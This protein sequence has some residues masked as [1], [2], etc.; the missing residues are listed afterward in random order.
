MV[1]VSLVQTNE[2]APALRFGIANNLW[3]YYCLSIVVIYLL[4]DKLDLLSIS[5]YKL[6]F[7]KTHAIAL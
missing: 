2:A 6:G 4:F 7:L 3:V 5:L 1:V